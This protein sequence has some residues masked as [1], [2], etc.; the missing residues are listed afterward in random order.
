MP[1][2]LNT[3][4]KQNLSAD[5]HSVILRPTVKEVT[6]CAEPRIRKPGQLLKDMFFD[7]MASRELAWR[8]FLRDV[9]SQ[10]R[11]TMLGYAWAIAPP[12]LTSLIFVLMHSAKILKVED[13]SISYPLYVLSGTMFFGI[14]SDAVN[15]PL[16]IVAASK[17]MIVK[18]NFPREALLLTAIF[19]T[20]FSAAIKLALLAVVLI[21]YR[22]E[23]GWSILLTPVP[24]FGLLLAGIMIGVLI[25]P[26][27]L[28]F[29]DFAYALPLVLNALMLVSPV[30][31]P[32][33]ATGL[34]SQVIELN[35]LT[36]LIMGC[37]DLIFGSFS[38]HWNGMFG[39][40]LAMV[41]IIILGWVIFRL[42]LP[43]VVERVG[44]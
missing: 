37:R 42:A 4:T 20:V 31:Y 33:P 19:S 26:A 3:S 39:I 24:I 17:S 14:F 27:G 5:N 18:V 40:F 13:V 11:Q 38:G 29:Q 28:L 8:L 25:V 41:F 32:P 7:L 15:A 22:T 35:P 34:L 30:A 12:L 2:T 1:E 44:S 6:R 10:Y 36:S 9:S 21:V 43:R 16:R 23:V